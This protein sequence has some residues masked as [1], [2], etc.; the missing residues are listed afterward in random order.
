MEHRR[1]VDITGDD[2]KSIVLK[3]GESFSADAVILATGAKWKELGI[4][5]E[6]EYLGQ[7]VAFCPHCDSPYFKG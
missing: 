4:P 3:D 7:G 1:V 6:K 5:G 2:K